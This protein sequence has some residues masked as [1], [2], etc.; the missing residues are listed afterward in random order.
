MKLKRSFEASVVSHPTTQGYILEV[1]SSRVSF[2]F[3]LAPSV[4]LVRLHYSDIC[5][6]CGLSQ[7]TDL[8]YCHHGFS[9]FSLIPEA[10][11]NMTE[12]CSM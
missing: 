3:F 1:L 7:V 6:I 5:E 8:V 11:Q 4:C 2:S 10:G 9:F 12:T